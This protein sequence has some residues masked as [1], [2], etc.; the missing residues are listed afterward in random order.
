MGLLQV[1]YLSGP[2]RVLDKDGA[3]A[4]PGE[5]PGAAAAAAA[6]AAVDMHKL[7]LGD[8]G[9]WEPWYRWAAT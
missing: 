8:G 7:A 4:Q 1:H 5:G 2:I 3:P 6:A 9:A